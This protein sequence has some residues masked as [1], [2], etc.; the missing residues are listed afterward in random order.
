MRRTSAASLG[1]LEA[2]AIQ[3]YFRCPWD[4]QY[5][6]IDSGITGFR[7][8]W[9]RPL[10]VPGTRFTYAAD[11]WTEWAGKELLSECETEFDA[12]ATGETWRAAG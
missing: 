9:A 4:W 5:L 8:C 10:Q 3:E 12:E 11:T 1:S 6:F 2:R 7:E